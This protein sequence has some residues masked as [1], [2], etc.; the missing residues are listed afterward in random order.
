MAAGHLGGEKKKIGKTSASK[1]RKRW[2][3]VGLSAKCSPFE[4]SHGGLIYCFSF[5]FAKMVISCSTS[6]AV[7]AI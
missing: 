6:Y 1:E 7:N 5:I 2:I 3:L 4:I